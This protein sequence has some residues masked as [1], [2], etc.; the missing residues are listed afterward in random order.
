MTAD[1]LSRCFL[2]IPDMMSSI[3][4]SMAAASMEV[5]N[6]CCFT[7]KVSKMPNAFMSATL[8][9][10]PS[11]PKCALPDAACRARRSVI[12][13]TTSAPQLCAKLRGMTSSASPTAL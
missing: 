4:S 1:G 8:P 11:M 7:A 5:L 10:L 3:R 12:A 2:L 9:V 6:V 13:R